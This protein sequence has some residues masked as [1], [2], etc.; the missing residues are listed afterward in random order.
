[1]GRFP[2]YIKGKDY[3]FEKILT[4]K[5][6]KNQLSVYRT[7]G[8]ATTDFGIVIRKEEKI[9]PGLLYTKII[10]SRY[11][12]CNAELYK[13]NNKKIKCIIPKYGNIKEDTLYFN[14]N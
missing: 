13:I 14:I 7:N 10:Y 1:M 6:G 4:Y 9:L 8:G 3:S 11:R 2:D 5:I 12:A